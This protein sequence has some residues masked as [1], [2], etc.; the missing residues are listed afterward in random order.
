MLLKEGELFFF[1]GVATSRLLMLW[2]IASHSHT[3][4]QH[5]TG[6]GVLLKLEEDVKSGKGCVGR[7]ERRQRGVLGGVRGVGGDMIK[8]IE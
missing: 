7:S 5:L 1:G 4:R 2:W 3:C 6:L 8:D